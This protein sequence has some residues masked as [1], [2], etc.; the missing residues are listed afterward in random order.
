MAKKHKLTKNIKSCLK[1]PLKTGVSNFSSVVKYFLYTAPNIDCVHSC[2]KII[3]NRANVIFE[4]MINAANMA[5]KYKSLTRISK[6]SFNQYG[7]QGDSIDFK[8][9]RMTFKRYG[10]EDNLTA[11]V[12]HI[13]NAFAH[14]LVYIWKDTRNNNTPYVL[15]DDYEK[16]KRSGKL[17][18]T[19][20]IVIPFSALEQWKSILENEIATG[21]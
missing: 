7:L 11:L 14:G 1:N 2:G 16:D 5:K 12:R 15:L 21:E 9:S 20:R 18:Q 13:R 6:A 4:E 10:S 3:D 17:S 19:A 8:E